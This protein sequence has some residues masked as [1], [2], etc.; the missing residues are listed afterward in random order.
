MKLV[1]VSQWVRPVGG[2]LVGAVIMGLLQL[3]W[4][5]FLVVAPQWRPT[6]PTRN[7]AVT[8]EFRRVDLLTF[9]DVDPTSRGQ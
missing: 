8:S 5:C 2:R 7:S 6:L 9:A 4:S 3:D 1:V